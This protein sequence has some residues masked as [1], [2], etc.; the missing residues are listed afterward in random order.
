MSR[1]AAQVLLALRRTSMAELERR[2]DLRPTPRS[3]SWSRGRPRT[4]ERS[5]IGSNAIAPRLDGMRVVLAV[6]EVHDLVRDALARVLPTAGAEV[7]LLGANAP[8]DGIVRAAIEEDADA[9]VVGVYNGNALDA[10]RTTGQRRALRGWSGTIYM[11]G[12][13]NQDTGHGLPIDA[14]PALGELGVRC[15]D[16]ADELL[17][18]LARGLNKPLCYVPESCDSGR[19]SSTATSAT[20]RRS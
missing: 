16:S 1:D 13:L 3:P 5:P 12:I 15:V 8:I 18:L 9:I 20:I 2:V 11:G 4:F 6:L 7:I 17:L 10:R 14:R 19:C